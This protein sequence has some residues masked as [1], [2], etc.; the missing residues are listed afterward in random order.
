[1]YNWLDI[2]AQRQ[3]YHDLVREVEHDRLVRQLLARHETGA[4]FYHRLLAWLGRVLI[5]AGKH[6]QGRYG[7]AAPIS[8]PLASLGR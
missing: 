6:L 7:N 4:R 3:H 5:A 8:K 2:V 1:M